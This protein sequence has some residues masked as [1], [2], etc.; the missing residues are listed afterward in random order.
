MRSLIRLTDYKVNEIYDIFKIADEVQEGNYDDIL[1]RKSVILFFP[2][3]S[4]RTRV[5]FEKSVCWVCCM[6]KYEVYI[7]CFYKKRNT[8]L[9]V[10]CLIIIYQW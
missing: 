9:G 4:I 7:V 1:K 8:R 3:S 5:S 2:N 10:T 6:Q